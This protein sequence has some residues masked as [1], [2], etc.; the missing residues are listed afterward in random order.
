[1]GMGTRRRRQRQEQ[2]WISHNELAQYSLV[3]K[4]QADEK[5]VCVNRFRATLSCFETCRENYL[6]CPFGK[7]VKHRLQNSTSQMR[8]DTSILRSLFSGITW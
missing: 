3:F 8:L 4:H 6:S 1:M 5:I 2:L 7:I